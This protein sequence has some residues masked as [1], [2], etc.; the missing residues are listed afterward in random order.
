MDR[1]RYLC[2]EGGHASGKS[3]LSA[4]VVA[5]FGCRNHRAMHVTF[6]S[7]RSFP[8]RLIRSYLKGDAMPANP[9][10]LLYLYAA[11]GYDVDPWMRAVIDGGSQVVADRHPIYS[12]RIYQLEHHPAWHIESVYATAELLVPD[13]LFVV[14]VPPE[15]AIERMQQREKYKAKIFETSD[16]EK[17]EVYRQRYLELAAMAV[18]RRLARRCHVLDGTYPMGDLVADAIS[19]AG[20]Y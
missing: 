3:S 13:V 20:P 11:D 10:S 15:V 19:L 1:G 14:D 6:P 16:V 9:K 17:M 12:G 8:G 4:A 18:D 7:D 5:E 2:F